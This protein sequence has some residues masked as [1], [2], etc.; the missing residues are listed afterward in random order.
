MLCPLSYLRTPTRVAIREE[1]LETLLRCTGVNPCESESEMDPT[2][3]RG[4]GNEVVNLNAH[5]EDEIRGVFRD[6]DDSSGDDAD[7]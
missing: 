4:K 1:E 6:G 2:R 5:A 3:R 7:G